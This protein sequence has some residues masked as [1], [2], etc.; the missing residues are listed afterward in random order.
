MPTP[1]E[2]VTK[3]QG[4]LRTEDAT[5]DIIEDTDL[6]GWTHFTVV[7]SIF[8]GKNDD[9]REDLLGVFLKQSGLALSDITISG[10]EIFA[11]KEEQYKSRKKKVLPL[12]ADVLT[13]TP[14][15]TAIQKE[16]SPSNKPQIV[17]FYSFKGGVGRTT[18]L[19]ISASILA[20]RGYRIAIVDFDLEA[21]GISLLAKETANP[22]DLTQKSGV[23]DYISQ[24][25]FNNEA[26]KPD[27]Q[28][29]IIPLKT[30]GAGR[31]EL[32][33]IPAGKID[34]AYVQKLESINM[35]SVY[36]VKH[37]PVHQLIE[38]ITKTVAPD[39]ILIDA[40]TGFA[41]SG[42]VSILDLADTS[43]ICFSPT[44]QNFEGLKPVMEAL[45]M[46]R[47]SQG[48]PDLRFLITPLAN[49]PSD[50]RK[51]WLLSVEE[52][53]SDQLELL[54]HERI[55]DLYH[56]INYRPDI[57]TLSSLISDIPDD[58]RVSYTPIADFIDSGMP[59][60]PSPPIL[61]NFPRQKI[62]DELSFQ[63]AAA[64]DISAQELP[65][66]FQK[67]GDFPKFIRQNTW[68]VIGPKGSGKSLIFRL[69]IEKPDTARE[70][71]RNDIDLSSTEFLAGHGKPSIKEYILEAA[72]LRSYEEQSGDVLWNSF[73]PH[74]TLLML[75][76]SYPHLTADI[77]TKTGMPLVNQHEAIITWLVTRAQ[78]VKSGPACVDALRTIDGLLKAEGKRTWIFYDELDVGFSLS[79]E[80]RNKAI[81]ALL[82]WWLESGSSFHT[83]QPKIL[84]RKDIWARLS[85]TNKAHYFTKLVELEWAEADLL[86]L[87]LRQA[88]TSST[89]FS[90]LISQK[91]KIAYA[92][93]D[94]IGLQQL[95]D[96]VAI[97]WG[98]RMGKI[99]KAY[100]HNWVRTRISDAE[101]NAFPRSLVQLLET[102]RQLE[103]K[104]TAAIGEELIR[105]RSLINAHPTV[106]EQRVAEV[107]AEY[108]ELA[109]PLEALRSQRSPIDESRL[110]EIWHLDEVSITNQ[111]SQFLEAGIFEERTEKNASVR[112]FAVAELYLLGLG[113]VRK[114][115]R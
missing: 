13:A 33:L 68:L 45:K 4:A 71:S 54:A 42:A 51:K 11:S 83:L 114:G 25:I 86:R 87:V 62:L 105:P 75:C 112:I 100:T 46:R 90:E 39:L 8:E 3:L 72:D 5:A 19:G 35:R 38:D 106:S 29:C 27:I 23:V 94:H 89:Q 111:I 108:P 50:T 66:I 12:W 113:M 96:C 15:T 28:D 78:D 107:R 36:T 17:A 91:L 16:E 76:R 32:F 1:T 60:S 55:Q 59:D 9:T 6:L 41:D 58:I 10:Y 109:S 20:S 21:P 101:G 37:N 93:L 95:I 65:D 18:A 44:P 69:F 115:Q 85:F 82:T 92:A 84:L 99:N 34:R 61:S 88:M 67:T 14:E 102:A 64:E 2:F 47:N 80:S 31:G 79:P 73:W 74:Y 63:P 103:L 30:S 56:T 81:Q 49:V 70:L 97:L 57:L 53:L 98:Y 22:D 43:I 77:S 26:T 24:R 48:K 110:K 52:W 7:S 104:S 40:R